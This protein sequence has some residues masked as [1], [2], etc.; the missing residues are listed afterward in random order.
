MVTTINGKKLAD[1]WLLEN[2]ARLSA[3][4]RASPPTLAIVQLGDENASRIYI[5]RKKNACETVGIQTELYQCPTTISEE[6]LL[7]HIHALN[8][9]KKITGILVQLPL[10]AHI[11]K[12]LIMNAI[13]QEKDVDAQSAYYLG[14]LVQDQ[15][16]FIPCTPKGIL[17]M[18][19]SLN[20]PLM[21]KDVLMIGASSLV[22]KPMGLLLLKEKCT[23]T[24]AH[25]ATKNLNDKISRA[26]IVITAIGK[27]EF[28]KAAY[29]QKNAIVIDVGINRNAHNQLVG[30]VDT[31]NSDHLAF[32]SPV[33][34]GVGPMTVAALIDNILIAA[35][36]G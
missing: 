3:L 16:H 24:I 12:T 5:E 18:L 33:P 31:T 27:A 4:K 36:H 23:V 30:D 29:C 26:D 14:A 35:S 10:P 15:P 22:G 20:V 28:I 17:R 7:Q 9:D 34:G 25:S 8:H 2:K 11:D 21:G 19:K 1:V 6:D 13:A 32:L